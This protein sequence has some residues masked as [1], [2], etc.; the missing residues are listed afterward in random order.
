MN[1]FKIGDV[2]KVLVIGTQPYGIFVRPFDDEEYTG[3]IHISEITTEF[4][5]NVN[6]FAKVGDILYAK[7]IDIDKNSKQL[8]LS[9]KACMPKNRYKTIYSKSTNIN[10]DASFADL[11]NNLNEWIKEQMKEK[12]QHDQT[13]H[14]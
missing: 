3:L 10:V 4:V 14:K 8:K 1:E 9:I 11:Q 5:R 12:K 7:I 13:R 2:I 6:S